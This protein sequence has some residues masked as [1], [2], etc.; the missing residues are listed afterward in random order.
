MIG[1]WIIGIGT[2]AWLCF[3]MGYGAAGLWW[4]LIGGAAAG[5]VMMYLRLVSRLSIMEDRLS[6]QA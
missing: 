4:G 3:P 6:A 1:Y 2:G 5:I